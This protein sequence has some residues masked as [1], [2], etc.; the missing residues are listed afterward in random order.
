MKEVSSLN[1]LIVGLGSIGLRHARNFS[2]LNVNSVYGFDPVDKRRSEFEAEFNSEAYS[3][4][5]QAL[6]NQPDLT[7]IASPNCFHLE[8]AFTVVEHGCPLFI[9]K[10]LSHNL[11]GVPEF[12]EQ[13]DNRSLF[14]HVGSNWKFHPAFKE[15]KRLIDNQTIGKVT[16]AQVISGWWLPDWH[17]WEDYRQMYSSR[18]ELGGG[19]VLD[20]H[21]FDYLTWLLG[22]VSEVSGYIS[23][24]NSLDI[25]TEDV[26]VACLKL[27]SGVLA[28]VHVDYIQRDYR[29]KYHI[30][31]DRGTIEWDYT[32]S[33]L[34][35]YDAEK[36]TTEQVYVGLSDLNEMY[37]EQAAH[38]LDGVLGKSE[39][40]TSAQA[41]AEVLRIL[42]TIKGEAS[43]Q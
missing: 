22:P 38:I 20:S 33:M 8:Q 10:P 9:E 29:R 40:V 3:S 14:V 35:V 12:L 26:A 16:G 39:A 30:S 18:K 34:S 28:T 36:D 43:E 21:E 13:I 1:V 17:P 25:E 19:I 42:C 15:M 27:E 4:L 41:A 31:G 6:S 23:H 24:S 5:E 11:I 37:I 7:V 2:L 32:T